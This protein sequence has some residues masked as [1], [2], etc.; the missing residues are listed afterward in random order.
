MS[1]V[2]K[3]YIFYSIVILFALFFLV[4]TPQI[5]ITNGT[6]II[7]PRHWPY[8]LLTLMLILAIFGI[9]KS[10]ILAKKSKSIESKDHEDKIE[11]ERTFFKL[12]IPMISLVLV[13][14][15]VL[16]LNAIGFI[17]STLLF[18]YG[19]SLLLGQKKQLYSIIFAVL[20]TVV[21]IGLF[22]VLLSI[23][24]PRGLGIFRQLSL[25]FY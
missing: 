18:L 17:I 1:N 16:L 19:I 7:G 15:Y 13:I 9:V 3:D 4:M 5:K 10:Y 25:L 20:T 8:I 21:F 22:S 6:F 12:S 11:P 23:P 14:L 2:M 24:L